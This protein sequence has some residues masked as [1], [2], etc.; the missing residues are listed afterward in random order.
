MAKKTIHMLIDDLDGSEADES[1]K[2]AIDG[3]QYEIDLSK[4]NVA[5][6]RDAL[7]PYVAVGT[8]AGRSGGI[9]RTVGA[10]RR[11]GGAAV[12]RDQNRAIRE[13]AQSKGIAVSDRGRI[14]QEIVDRYHAEAG[15]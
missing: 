3:V 4:E 9:V 13:W 7:A 15:H 11:R 14:K 6:L 2:F 1:V 8:K 12:D 10:P 5:K